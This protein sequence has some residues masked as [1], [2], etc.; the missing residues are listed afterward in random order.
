MDLEKQIIVSPFNSC[1]IIANDF[2]FFCLNV[3]L[4]DNFKT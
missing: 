1:F 3:L 4:G 2:Y